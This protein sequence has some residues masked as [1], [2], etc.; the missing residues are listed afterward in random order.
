MNITTLQG[1]IS[2]CI[3]GGLFTL[4][5]QTAKEQLSDSI[6]T[7]IGLIPEQNQTQ[8][9]VITGATQP[10][11]A[12][13]AI[14]NGQAMLFDGCPAYSV[15]A[16]FYLDSGGTPQLTLQTTGLPT[17]WS[18]S[19]TFPALKST[20]FDLFPV[21]QP[22]FI[23][24]S[25]PG[26][27]AAPLLVG[28]NFQ[29]GLSATG[30]L[31]QA[32]WMVPNLT[33]LPF[34]GTITLPT[35]SGEAPTIALSTPAGNGINLGAFQVNSQVLLDSDYI[36]TGQNRVL[37]TA[38]ELVFSIPVASGP[39][40]VNI[41]LSM[42]LSPGPTNLLTFRA[43]GVAVPI[44]NWS[45][46][47][48][49]SPSTDFSGLVPSEMPSAE[50]LVITD[51]T[52]VVSPKQKQVASLAVT[53][54]L[55]N[56]AWTIIPG[57]P[58][59]P[60]V[61]VLNDA[62]I[63]FSVPFLTSSSPQATIFGIFILAGGELQLAVTAP[64]LLVTAQLV[65]GQISVSSLIQQLVQALT[66]SVP[67]LPGLN[68]YE[69]DMSADMTGNTY[70]LTAGIADVWTMTL[71]STNFSMGI[72]S[73]EI[74]LDYS[75]N[76]LA[77]AFVGTVDID[78][79]DL[80]VQVSESPGGWSF[81][82]GTAP[83]ASLNLVSVIQKF[84]S[85]A[86]GG[87]G[88][89]PSFLPQSMAVTNVEFGIESATDDQGSTSS[90]SYSF[91]A[92][93]AGPWQ[94]TIGSETFSIAA[95][96]AITYQGGKGTSGTISGALTVGNLAVTVAYSFLPNS[97]TITAS[98][99]YKGATLTGTISSGQG[100]DTIVTIALGNLSFG[101]IVDWLVDLV[102]PSLD[103]K[104]PTPWDVLYDI[105]FNGLTLTVNMTKKSVGIS[106]PL[107]KNLG[108][109]D[110][111]TISLTYVTL[112]GQGTVN[113][114]FT[115][116]FAGQ[117]FG[118]ETPLQWDML[119][120]SPPTPSAGAQTFDLQYLGLGQHVTLIDPSATTM[121][122]VLSG[123]QKTVQ[124]V[125]GDSTPPWQN[126]QFAPSSSLLFGTLFSVM[127]TVT[128]GAVFNDP[129]L[130]G[131]NI[132][133]AGQKAGSFA[134]L[135]FEILYRKIN[136]SVGVYHIDL[137]LPTAMRT[138][139]FGSVSVTLPEVI[140]DIYTNGDF[141]LDFGFPYNNDWSN[142]FG[143]QIFPFVGAGGFYFGK[144]SAATATNMPKITNGTFDPVIEFGLALS[145]G[146]GKTISAGP[147]SG[148]VTLQVQGTLIGVLSWFNPNDTSASSEMYYWI[149][150][151]IAIVGNLYAQVDFV[152][153]KV[154][155][156]VTAY[157]SVTLTVAAYQPILI[158]MSVGVKVTASVKVVFFTIHFSFSMHLD[159]SFTI[160]H[161]SPTPWQLAS[162][163]GGGSTQSL[164][165]ARQRKVRRRRP[166]PSLLTA[167]ASN[168]AQVVLNF[169]PV[170][171]L[172]GTPVSVPVSLM[173]TFTV[174]G[175]TNPAV[176]VVMTPYILNTV[177][178]EAQSFAATRRLAVVQG[179]DP[180][181]APFNLIIEGLLLW[182]IQALLGRTSG[183]ISLQD[184]QNLYYALSKEDVSTAG[185]T[186][187]NLESFMGLNYL[188]LLSG[189]PENDPNPAGGTIFPMLPTLQMQPQGETSVNFET[190]TATDATYQA[191]LSA[192]FSQLG[193]NTSY[194]QPQDPTQPQPMSDGLRNTLDTTISMAQVIFTDY[195]LMVMTSAV[196]GAI[197]LLQAYPYTTQSGDSLASMA[198]A[199]SSDAT[200]QVQPDETLTSI[201]QAFEVPAQ[202]IM[203]ANPSVNFNQPF[204]LP[205]SLVIPPATV[206]ATYYS[207]AGD[208]L[209]S[210]AAGFQVEAAAIQSANP[211]VDFTDL[212]PGTA[213]AIPVSTML[214]GIVGAAS[215]QTVN[216]PVTL[217][218]LTYQVG[219]GATLQS[220][221]TTFG[222]TNAEELATLNANSDSVLLAGSSMTIA[223]DG[224]TI[225]YVVQTGDSFNLVAAYFYVRNLE[226]LPDANLGWFTQSI[227]TLNPGVNLS[228]SLS[229]GTSLT[230]PTDQQ[231]NTTSYTTKSGDTLDLVAGYFAA[232]FGQDAGLVS[233]ASA[234]QTAYP[235]GLTAGQTIQVPAQTH[236]VQGQDTLSALATLFG[237]T[238][239]N[240]A[241]V[242]VGAPILAAQAVLA[243][244]PVTVAAGKTLS[245]LANAY[246]ISLDDLVGRI[247][248]VQ[249]LL[250][251]GTALTLPPVISSDIADLVTA[252]MNEEPSV[253]NNI[254]GMVSR[255]MLYGAQLPLPTDPVF[256]SLTVEQIAAGEA[257]GKVALAPLYELT[258]QQ[259][260]APD[261]SAGDFAITFTNTGGST[262]VQFA[263][264]YTSQQGDTLASIATA[265]S[266]T[267]SALQAANPGVS[268]SGLQ[269][270][271]LL[272]I[273]NSPSP[274]QI[275]LT[276]DFMQAN[277]PAT[278]L[279][280]QIQSGPERLPLL[281][282]MPVQYG[283][284]TKLPWQAG[285]LPP[286]AP[287]ANGGS[288]PQSGQPS[289]WQFPTGLLDQLETA[290]AFHPYGLMTGS[291]TDP[292]AAPTPVNFYNWATVLPVTVQQVPAGSGSGSSAN[293][294]ELIGADQD[295]SD[296]LTQLWTYL[297]AP[298]CTDSAQLYLLYS[299]SSTSSNNSG[300]VS[301]ALDMNN[302]VL[303]KT[304]LSTYTL[305]GFQGGVQLLATE[306]APPPSGDYYASLGAG[307]QFIQLL[308]EASITGTGGFYLNYRTATG[309]GLPSNLFASSTTATIYLVVI[310]ASESAASDPNRTLY[311]FHN[312]AVVLDNID[313]DHA[314]LFAEATDQSDM[315]EVATVPPGNIG[316]TLTRTNASQQP[317]S[318]TQITQALFNLLGYGLPSAA[319]P[320]FGE[321][322][323]GFPT[324]PTQPT[325]DEDE[326]VWT[327][328][329]VVPIYTLATNPPT[330]VAPGLPPAT[331][332]PYAGL[333]SGSQATL[334]FAF[335]DI[336]GN[337]MPSS[338]AVP[339]LTIPVGYY[340][341]LI[342]LGNWP[343]AAAAY[344]FSASAQQEPQLTIAL[345]LDL[346][347][348]VAGGGLS[349][350]TAVYNAATDVVKYVQIYYQV[351]QSDVAF[352]IGTSFDSPSTPPAADPA[353]KLTL[354][355]FA[356]AAYLFLSSAQSLLPT[357]VTLT[358][359]S[360]LA[361][362]TAATETSVADVLNANA[363][364]DAF[365]IIDGT[366]T[367]PSLYTYQNGDTLGAIANT[368]GLPAQQLAQLNEQVPLTTG[369]VLT[370][371]ARFYT[372]QSGD[373]LQS[374]SNLLTTTASDLATANSGTPGVLNPGTVVT[375]NSATVTVASGDTF[376]SLVAAFATQGVTVTAAELGAAN[377]TLQNLL[378]KGV[379]IAIADT[380]VAQGDTSGSR[381][382]TTASGDTLASIALAQ[383]CTV[384]GLATANSQL[385]G[386]LTA[387]A[388]VTFQGVTLTV[389]STD[390]F[391]T[392]VAQLLAQNVTASVAD[393]AVANQS[394]TNLLATGQKITLVDYVAQPGDTLSS[395]LAA[396]TEFSLTGLVNLNLAAPTNLYPVG[397]PLLRS[398]S[399]YEVLP[400]ETLTNIAS[401]NGGLTVT[402]L[403]PYNADTNLLADAT[404]IL[405][406]AVQIPSGVTLYAPYQASGS[407]SLGSIA[408]YLNQ[409]LGNLGTLN[410]TMPNLINPG[411]TITATGY[412][413]I[414]TQATDTLATLAAQWHLS[415][416]DFVSN[417]AVSAMTTLIQAGALFVADLPTVSSDLTLQQLATNL[418][419][420]L[421]DLA[422]ANGSMT[423]L[424][425]SGATVTAYT[426]SQ[427]T[428]KVGQNDTLASLVARF[429]TEQNVQTSVTLI[430][431]ANGSLASLLQSLAPFLVPPQ[432]VQI[433][434][435]V[436]NPLIPAPIFPLSVTV[437]ESRDASLIDP[438]F[439]GVATVASSQTVLG[440]AVPMGSSGAL[441][442]SGIAT[443][444]EQAFQ[445]Y[446][447]KLAT[448]PNPDDSSAVPLWVV[449]L[450]AGGFSQ[451]AVQGNDPL[452]FG[453]SP[454]STQLIN[455][456]D[457]PVQP[458]E[459]DGSLGTAQSLSFQSIDPERWVRELLSAIDLFLSPQYAVPAYQISPTDYTSVVTAKGQIAE[460]ILP[461]VAPILAS[462]EPS[463]AALAAAQE[464]L[465]QSLLV[466][467]SQGYATDALLQFPVT[468]TSPFAPPYTTGAA[469]GFAEPAAYYNV[470]QQAFAL[471]AADLPGA[472]N[473]GQT[474]SYQSQAYTIQA[475]D[476]LG[477]I[478]QHYGVGVELLPGSLTV[479][480]GGG[481][482]APEVTL[483]LNVMAKAVQSTDSFTSLANYFTT[484]V[485]NV[486]IANENVAN[487]IPA[488]TVV[489][490]GTTTYTVQTGD[491]LTT[492]AKA[493][494]LTPDQFAAEPTISTVAGLLAGS[495]TLYAFSGIDQ[496]APRFVGRGSSQVYQVP[497]GLTMQGLNAAF[498]VSLA[499]LVNLI[500]S[501]NG[502]LNTG[503]TFTFNAQ[504]YSIKPGDTLAS[505]AANLQTDPLTLVE[506]M[507]LPSDQGLFAPNSGISLLLLSRQPVST[508]TF[509]SL[510]ELFGVT[511]A[512]VADAN[513]TTVGIINAGTVIKLSTGTSYTVQASD[514]L[515]TIATALGVTV[516]QVASDPDV[517]L[518]TGLFSAAAT[519]YMVLY[520]PPVA[521]S[522]AKT[523]L[524]DGDSLVTFL[525]STSADASY[526]NLLLS[527]NYPLNSLEYNVASVPGIE[528]Y[529]SSNWLTFINPL[530]I[531][532]SGYNVDTDI[533]LIDIPIPLRFYPPLPTLTAQT[534][535]ASDPQ[536]T[537]IAAAKEWSFDF[538]WEHQDA[539]QDSATIT[540]LFNQKPTFGALFAGNP[541]LYEALA[542]F[543]SVWAP[544]QSLLTGLLDLS[545]PPPTSGPLVNAVQSFAT[546][547]TQVAQA[548]S[549]K[550]SLGA[551]PPGGGA[552]FSYTYQV[553]TTYD[554]KPEATYRS[555]LVLTADTTGAPWPEV[556][557]PGDQNP[558]ASQQLGASTMVYAYP[559]ETPAFTSLVH[560]F[561]FPGNDV[562]AVQ[563]GQS[564]ISIARNEILIDGAVTNQA[565][566][567]QTPV[568]SYPNLT[569]PLVQNN[570]AITINAGADLTSSL[571]Q[572]FEAILNASDPLTQSFQLQ[573]GFN[574]GHVLVN[575]PEGSGMQPI[576]SY[577]PGF[578]AP[579]ITL[580]ASYGIGNLVAD[581]ESQI[582]IFVKQY[583]PRNAAPDAY[584]LSVTLFA[585]NWGSQPPPLLQ[586]DS[587]IYKLP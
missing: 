239:V 451:V 437:N 502:I 17:G 566:V 14:V 226:R 260:V 482:F 202:A 534:W 196:Q 346:S 342:G 256:Q 460:A 57:A 137:K 148:G 33:E 4:T 306:E 449:S 378:V 169:T 344:S 90:T 316:F 513:A 15:S 58:G 11:S 510:S 497:A 185:F 53:V 179:A 289:I 506:Q 87:S 512:Q 329:Q 573:V 134:G 236:I 532:G 578:L 201:A 379:S 43:S 130:Y 292:L 338:P 181:T 115:G 484:T 248:P 234:L 213:L 123:L 6:A 246:A 468:V 383:D 142:S 281:Q 469:D 537:T 151:T 287:G 517:V 204:Q 505:I 503:V 225:P 404:L 436:A 467:L 54:E 108:I 569:V 493:F 189:L 343:G 461:Q 527:M 377:N 82:I 403:A 283:L 337:T 540:V 251:A 417:A 398:T 388:F 382:Y 327:Y 126:L 452:F 88:F 295:G 140:V 552:E 321:V 490:V 520:V 176:Q 232:I 444:F 435:P 475:S 477:T 574:Y 458:L 481:L 120:Q 174:A 219:S 541:A 415:A 423:G 411:Q 56:L 44:N 559:A 548:W 26:A 218:G 110:I 95:A 5:A 438:E 357:T 146:A 29:S 542:Q 531:S 153:I 561:V 240:L 368:T 12:T 67:T 141:Y 408:Q 488:G 360:T 394:V 433:V 237:V 384:I 184:L 529:Q 434:R 215:G 584:S 167:T 492:I 302:T 362:F 200:Y 439:E 286:F 52:L 565:F 485:G 81:M 309:N 465:K 163:G 77:V 282:E 71:P 231:G 39:P 560:R 401:Q 352:S 298:G 2:G 16:I 297:T 498:P 479:T 209:D 80:Q 471:A 464:A 585:N 20:I 364:E 380:P 393:L 431:E 326:S 285:A 238:V 21:T 60:P 187:T 154:N 359:A 551:A 207:L 111:G 242:N 310:L 186:P 500:D 91:Q 371:A 156:S 133:L 105:N 114:G 334:S 37:I 160:G 375:Y 389:G 257:N 235:G 252:L 568:V 229:A 150:G 514:T 422:L 355:N 299:P 319:N 374:I 31:A 406:N 270:G 509:E 556:Y 391:A 222:F 407:D 586:L 365:L 258:G 24:A 203:Q 328:E 340:D 504:P 214:F 1:I 311:P 30:P 558:L 421:D 301:D 280:P 580:N 567:Y 92:Q 47:Q 195:N 303:L 293:T 288:Q 243:L 448:G 358:Q 525:F 7:L 456:S 263:T 440:A 381:T 216:V 318:S 339:N 217:A 228:Q 3:S 397:T 35:T 28:I 428:I 278:T 480:S 412:P 199:F 331:Q 564:Q 350:T 279:D 198:A 34:S 59:N 124:S 445:S 545:G 158:A 171:V 165:V 453:I 546:L 486:A 284:G 117:T 571:T 259:L 267:Q 269:A 9:L 162:S 48:V 276:T 409:Y 197:D 175:A 69:L 450:G 61:L 320:F 205:L 463:A 132:S 221:V 159:A 290:T 549:G 579:Q 308:W 317:P 127:G 79:L 41:Q 116:S 46:L 233:L 543:D 261:P 416:S 582:Q 390:T 50:S 325:D 454:L 455:L 539:A 478:A 55:V 102:D 274:F 42:G 528:G 332:N 443:S 143:L 206:N 369:A 211:D 188:L 145:I 38:G 536:A 128:L 554:Y 224:G 149:Q 522:T 347:R 396:N 399:T 272:T 25:A 101:E 572:M 544:L 413:E 249:N 472:L 494:G 402:Q 587:L 336:F 103:F 262:W 264:A 526:R 427:A 300:L 161:A 72:E 335:Y 386:L 147:L 62:G 581:I 98:I 367:I 230:V 555:Q 109:I 430:A 250:A 400:G 97:E 74:A 100:Q 173:P 376:D 190:F 419:V 183:T 557:V 277:F 112:G 523:S 372:T 121:P 210:I 125:Q 518:Q 429:S 519:I 51:L 553:E 107:N 424:L 314:N 432:A 223:G 583:Q 305:G 366:L 420:T 136:D 13:Q 63:S 164:A 333:G 139:Q 65:A 66:G 313:P 84:L 155:V 496:A 172:G 538:S 194:T 18:F 395:V 392:L 324:G 577:M 446:S 122:Q 425:K 119:N 508:D 351:Q 530:A 32:S 487:I 353:L 501:M 304:N 64:E 307:T 255:F 511:V 356:S 349:Y 459:Q 291:P 373:T 49:L 271:T 473:A 466:S 457:V 254:A 193:G 570:N 104:L 507:V 296:L 86:F 268:W 106:Y 138:L 491:T 191:K 129:Q 22:G 489:T 322:A 23:F 535:E 550:D 135:Y 220:V 315:T 96:V 253:A 562:A 499:Y 73:L 370:T 474:V 118:P 354:Q 348:Y 27:A 462:E 208:S 516:D 575:P 563:N 192:Y 247:A 94:F 521:F 212:Q 273:P 245:D 275:T 93:T 182:G 89:W 177:P 533:G 78:G 476:T 131:M 75:N 45:D 36:G 227:L 515:T 166:A 441:S 144:L 524:A 495:Q 152:V 405:P 83:G 385:Q 99:A 157:A 170:A 70:S 547:V 266:V 10:A 345:D 470:S 483:D 178:A 294:L 387:G 76:G 168:Q 410:A 312:C 40:P 85:T 442:L 576:I 8:E 447:L 265:F 241:D 113:I 363:S 426:G 341:T 68:I 418:G 414:H 19:Q 330:Q 361:E 323:E 244:P 180:G